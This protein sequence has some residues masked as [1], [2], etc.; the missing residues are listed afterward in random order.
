MTTLVGI[1]TLPSEAHNDKLKEMTKGGDSEII[2]KQVLA[3]GK[4]KIAGLKVHQDDRRRFFGL[5]PSE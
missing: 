1:T 4:E 2:L 5:M 3:C